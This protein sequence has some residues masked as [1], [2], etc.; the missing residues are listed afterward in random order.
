[1][2]GGAPPEHEDSAQ[3][4]P[5]ILKVEWNDLVKQLLN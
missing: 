5:A 3:D 2:L 4:V 1:M